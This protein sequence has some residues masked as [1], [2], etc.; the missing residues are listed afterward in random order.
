MMWRCERSRAKSKPQIIILSLKRK[1][2]KTWIFLYLTL[3]KTSFS[4]LTRTER[5]LFLNLVELHLDK[6]T[7]KLKKNEEV[8]VSVI[9]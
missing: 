9:L 5:S 2:E 6:K 1:Q 4:A 3:P 7:K 8:Y